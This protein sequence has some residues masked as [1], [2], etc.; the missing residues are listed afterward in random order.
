M[1]VPIILRQGLGVADGLPE[2]HVMEEPVGVARP[3]IGERVPTG[4]RSA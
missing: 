1:A 2:A 4:Q 3:E